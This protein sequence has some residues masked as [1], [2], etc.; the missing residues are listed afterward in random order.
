MPDQFSGCCQSF[1]YQR[2]S[3]SSKGM[4]YG[5]VFP[6]L[7]FI[8]GVPK[9]CSRCGYQQELKETEN[10]LKRVR[11]TIEHERQA[12]EAETLKLKHAQEAF[13][14]ESAKFLFQVRRI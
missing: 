10:E 13:K 12:M 2:F 8:C 6:L 9:I 5:G 7:M 14:Q 4:L 11:D 1:V 3:R